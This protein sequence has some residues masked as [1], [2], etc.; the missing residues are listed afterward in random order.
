MNK[1][2]IRLTTGKKYH[3]IMTKVEIDKYTT[4]KLNCNMNLLE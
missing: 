4:K 3:M 2:K 1:K